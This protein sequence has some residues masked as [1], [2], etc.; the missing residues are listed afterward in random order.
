MC[1]FVVIKKTVLDMILKSLVEKTEN[2]LDGNG[3]VNENNQ[4]HDVLQPIMLIHE[5]VRQ[6]LGIEF[7]KLINVKMDN[8]QVFKKKMNIIW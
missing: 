6:L 3:N 7:Q 8:L 4:Q 5:D 2:K 1:E